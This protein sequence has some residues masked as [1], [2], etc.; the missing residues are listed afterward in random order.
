M[1]G[2]DLVK[3]VRKERDDGGADGGGTDE[4]GGDRL[5]GALALVAGVLDGVALG[6]DGGMLGGE[7]FI[8]DGLRG[9]L[10]SA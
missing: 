8:D 1:P 6:V 7:V 9:V 10:G 4:G 5:L 2:G 3:V